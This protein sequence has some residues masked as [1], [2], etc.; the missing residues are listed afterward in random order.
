MQKYLFFCILFASLTTQ[1]ALPETF[2]NTIP[3]MNRD[4]AYDITKLAKIIG[5]KGDFFRLKLAEKYLKNRKFVATFRL[6]NKV[7][8]P[9]F[10]F[11]KKVLLSKY[12]LATDKP[13]Q[14]LALL[15]NLPPKPDHEIFYGEGLYDNLY[16]RALISLYLAQKQL[17]KKAQKEAAQ[18]L[19]L[20]PHDEDVNEILDKDDKDPTLTKEQKVDKLHA[21]HARYLLKEIPGLMTPHEIKKAKISTKEK[22]R[23]YYELGNGNRFRK[24]TVNISAQAFREL[25][26]LQCDDYFTTRALYRLGTLKPDDTTADVRKQYLTR[27]YKN[28]PDHRLADDAVYKLYKISNEEHN[29][30]D[31]RKYYNQLMGLKKGDMKSFLAF[32]LAYP[33]YKKQNYKKAAAILGKA[34]NTESTSDESYPKLLYWYARSLEK[35]KNKKDSAKAKQT[36]KKIAKEFPYSFHAIFAAK[37]AGTTIKKPEIPQLTGDPPSNETEYFSLIDEFNADKHHEAARTVLD[38]ALHKHPKWL[39]TDKQYITEKLIA[40]QNYRK[41]IDLASKH[42]GGGVYGPINGGKGDPMFAAFYPW[43]FRDKTGKGYETS[44]LPFGAIE[45]IM[46]EESLFQRT[47]KS[48]VGAM[49]LMQLMPATAA[50]LKKNDLPDVQISSN[51][52]DPESNIILGSTYLKKMNTYFQ[53]QLPL[54]IMAYNAGPGNVNKWLRKF[55]EKE[56]DEFIEEIPFQETKGYVKR[57]MRTMQVYGGLYKEPYFEKPDY[58]SFNIERTEKQK[59]KPRKK[60]RRRRKKRKKR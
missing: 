12:Y 2:L 8:D 42:F 3:E 35:T 26:K 44:E 5:P 25:L 31:A 9:I 17:G 4:Y 37:R 32:E 22:C 10:L 60:K 59:Q 47:A 18:L 30:S 57:V 7:K 11:W 41:A 14:T 50:M 36:Y 24:D 53:N 38:F 48:R 28:F 1:A 15:R 46:R 16:K 19:S 45:G 23:A 33:H 20:Y 6:L 55:G 40:S 13:R 39:K 52:T 54:A 21:L 56:L 51:L 34:L 27:L 29:A 43:A 49:G 58:F